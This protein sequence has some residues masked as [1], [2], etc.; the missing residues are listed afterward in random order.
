MYGAYQVLSSVC[1]RSDTNLMHARNLGVVFGR[2]YLFTALE[3]RVMTSVCSD[4]NALPRSECRVQRH[5]RQGPDR[6]MA[7]RKRP[8]PL[9]PKPRVIAPSY[10]VYRSLMT[11]RR[12]CLLHLLYTSRP[13]SHC[14]AR[15]RSPSLSITHSPRAHA[16][17]LFIPRSLS[18]YMVIFLRVRSS[19]TCGPFVHFLF[20]RILYF[21]FL[22]QVAR[23]RV[24]V[25]GASTY[26]YPRPYL[27]IIPVLAASTDKDMYIIIYWV[28]YSQYIHNLLLSL[29]PT[30]GAY[31]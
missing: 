3:C 13:S 6:R 20:F 5:G 12:Y 16:R 1:Q 22:L 8:R 14:V 25:S 15:P 17:S 28:H 27:Y 31:A 4:I 21:L 24:L 19:V 9:R 29:R 18:L 11:S 26:N 7:C 23:F 10:L 2:K 30:H